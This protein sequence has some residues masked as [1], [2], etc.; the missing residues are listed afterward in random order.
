[1]VTPP[2]VV[3]GLFHTQGNRPVEFGEITITCGLEL[4][5]MGLALLRVKRLLCRHNAGQGSF[6]FE[7]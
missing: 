2:A 6:T 3:L 7:Y 5:A 1:V 4:P